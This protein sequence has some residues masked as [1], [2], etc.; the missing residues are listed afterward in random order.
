MISRAWK[1]FRPVNAEEKGDGK[2]K[3]RNANQDTK[4][5]TKEKKIINIF[6]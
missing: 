1:R 2:N 5:R 4:S 6:G 3:K